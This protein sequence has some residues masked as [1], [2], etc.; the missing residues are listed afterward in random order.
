VPPRRRK[1]AVNKNSV[2]RAAGWHARGGRNVRWRSLAALGVCLALLG[3]GGDRK[4]DLKKQFEAA[5]GRRCEYPAVSFDW[6][7]GDVRPGSKLMKARVEVDAAG[8]RYVASLDQTA[9]GQMVKVSELE[10]DPDP[11]PFILAEVRY[12]GGRL[13]NFEWKRKDHEGYDR[14]V[15]TKI[16]D[17]VA[18]AGREAMDDR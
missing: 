13:T 16:A 18:A 12:D 17:G 2:P 15:L 8:K 14:G 11:F 9:M 3:C 1:A 10:G 5:V 6:E 4:A 7:H